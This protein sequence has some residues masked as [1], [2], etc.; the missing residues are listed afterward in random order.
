MDQGDGK[1]LAKAW[2]KTYQGLAQGL[3]KPLAA[4]LPKPL[5]P[6]PSQLQAKGTGG[7]A[8]ASSSPFA[9]NNLAA[10]AVA[11][12]DYHRHVFSAHNN[13]D[14]VGLVFTIILQNRFH[15]ITLH[16]AYMYALENSCSFNVLPISSSMNA[17]PCH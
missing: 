13:K 15:S 11:T 12:I 7:G 14:E 17:T 5:P 4:M 6:H 16:L 2:P 1:G 9:H 3:G 8:V 10:A